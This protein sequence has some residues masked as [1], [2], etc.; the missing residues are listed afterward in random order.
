MWKDGSWHLAPYV[1]WG[2][3]KKGKR[4]VNEGVVQFVAN[5]DERAVSSREQADLLDRRK[6]QR[7]H[8]RVGNDIR[9]SRH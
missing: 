7:A 6:L 5:G 9:D 1:W 8:H 4:V 2:K 3:N